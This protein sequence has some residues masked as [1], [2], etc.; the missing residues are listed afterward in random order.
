MLIWSVVDS[1]APVAGSMTVLPSFP[2]CAF[3]VSDPAVKPVVVIVTYWEVVVVTAAPP[4]SEQLALATG[5]GAVSDTAQSVLSTVEQSIGELNLRMICLLVE[6]AVDPVCCMAGAV[7][8]AVA[9]PEITRSPVVW[10]FD[11]PPAAQTVLVSDP[12]ADVTR[13]KS[14]AGTAFF[15]STNTVVPEPEALATGSAVCV[16]P[17]LLLVP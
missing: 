15:S 13:A 17:P 4:E 9:A 10:Q 2:F 16:P 12:V 1:A 3:T 7:P 11:V 5:T 8:A 14:P 6:V